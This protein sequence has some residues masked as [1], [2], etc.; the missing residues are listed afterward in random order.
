MNGSAPLTDE[1]ALRLLI[2][3]PGNPAMI[4]RM[5][6][7]GLVL[8]SALG[9]DIRLPSEFPPVLLTVFPAMEGTQLSARIRPMA[10]LLEIRHGG[11]EWKGGILSAGN[12]V[13]IGS[14]FL[15][16]LNAS[17]QLQPPVIAQGES[18]LPIQHA[19]PPVSSP[20]LQSGTTESKRP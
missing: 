16:V 3:V 4:W 8:G 12:K 20:A 7:T 15:G 18:Y 19:A 13:Q 6:S 1:S 2:E 17:T 9:C 11:K 5:P 14:L 10:P